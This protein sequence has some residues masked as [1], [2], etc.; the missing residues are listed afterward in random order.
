MQI[1]IVKKLCPICSRNKTRHQGISLMGHTIPS[2]AIERFTRSKESFFEED[3][4]IERYKRNL[5]ESTHH[6]AIS[7]VL[8]F[9]W[10]SHLTPKQLLEMEPRKLRMLLTDFETFVLN[11]Y[12]NPTL[13]LQK[14]LTR[15]QALAIGRSIKGFLKANFVNFTETEYKGIFQKLFDMAIPRKKNYVPTK[16]DI[17]KAYSYATKRDKLVIHFLTNCC[18]RREELLG[19]TWKKLDLDR[20]YTKLDLEDFE[21]KGHGRGKYSGCHYTMIICESLR[22]ALIEYKEE[23]LKRFRDNLIP[24]SEDEF[25]KR[26]IFSSSDITEDKGEKT[27]RPL[28]YSSLGNAFDDL[29]KKSGVPL[30]CHSFRYY[31]QGIAIRTLG[32]DSQWIYFFLGHKLPTI[33]SHYARDY[34]NYDEVLK[35]F[36]KLEPYLDLFYDETKVKEQLT[37]RAIELQREGKDMSEIIDTVVKERNEMFLSEITQLKTRMV[38][39]QKES[40]LEKRRRTEE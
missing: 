24:I 28:E 29:R 6:I 11:G 14:Y 34:E 17:R 21:L 23:T 15:T 32:K 30:S 18:L 4:A 25:K 33:L 7:S 26:A 5:S 20:E 2:E 3:N 39:L 9:C 16:I 27:I 37:Q 38:E 31:S 12:D 36:K 1:D 35:A 22:K 10:I 40:E 19:L 8:R 13:D